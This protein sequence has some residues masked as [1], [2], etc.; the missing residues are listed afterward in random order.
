MEKKNNWMRPALLFF[1]KVSG[2]IVVP[3]I[4]GTIIGQLLDK[5]WGSEPWAFLVSVGIAF[6]ISITVII[7]EAFAYLR[8]IQKK[9]D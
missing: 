4:L 6:I 5:R 8:D 7:R 1:F 3:V 9:E 2:F